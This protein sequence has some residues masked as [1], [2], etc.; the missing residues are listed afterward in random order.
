MG[1]S[2]LMSMLQRSYRIAQTSI[3]T[4][5]PVTELVDMF[6]H[7]TTRRRF[8][9]SGLG[10]VSAIAAATWH[11]GNNQIAAAAV[12]KVLI[13]GAG[14]AGL[15]AGYRLK[16]AGVP[17][18]IIEARNRIGGRIY[19][20]RNVGGTR[21]YA[22]IGGEFI[23]TTHTSL[24]RLA[25]ELNLETVDLYT[26]DQKLAPSIRYYQGRK[27]EDTEVAEWNIPLVKKV[28]QDLAVLGNVSLDSVNTINYRTRNP[29]AIKLDNTSISEYLEQAQINPI[30][31]QLLQNAY[32]GLYG[33]EAAEQSCL[34][35]LL[36]IGTN[37][38]GLN[39]TG[40][41]DER[42][43]IK[44]G[45]DQIPTLLAKALTN[46]IETGTELEA[47]TTQPDGRYQVS[48][49]AGNRTF[50]KIYERVLLALPYT[51]L[52]AVALNID[53]P[54][55]KQKA[56]AELGYGTNSK[57][58]TAY[59]ERIW[60]TRYKSTAF[61][62]TDL[63]FG[64]TW[65][66]TRNHR[67]V[68]GIITNFTGGKQGF[69]IGNGAAESQA[70]KF[71]SQ[72]EQIFPDISSYRQ[73]NALRAYW[74][75]EEYTQ[76]SYAC[77]LVGQWTGISGVEQQSVDNIFFAGEHCSQKFQGYMEGGCRTGEIAARNILF[78][79]GLKPSQ[80]PK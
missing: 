14:I 31:N 23:D 77:Y 19:T 37:G 75:G 9:Y 2:T 54:P 29:I 66:A 16:Q 60:R 49:R 11:D 42:Y 27:I 63:G 68:P 39:I 65:E 71:L 8:I 53:L 72:L 62:S 20:A 43:Q 57:L 24:R 34:N 73:G 26:A 12:P 30:L 21:I 7:K 32:T 59:K 51:T 46:S 47:I 79:L 10:I 22:D 13:V 58:I 61:V 4:G 76:G 48:I 17:V 40:D 41:S 35:M 15:T 78:S 18:D 3:E 52:R 38:E 74:T 44:G 5:I 6:K 50:E 25:R 36:F 69:A 33:R 1:K 67:S 28:K 70:Q 56:I 64:Y 55:L 80:I 45:N